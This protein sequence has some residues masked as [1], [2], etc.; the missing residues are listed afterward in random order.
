M[1]LL[2]SKTKSFIIHSMN[3][4]YSSPELYYNRWLTP[5]LRD[6][7]NDTS[8]LVLTGARQV[9]KSTLLLHEAPFSDF[10]FLTLDDF[11]TLQQAKGDPRSLFSGADRIVID[12]VQRE[13]D[14]LLAVKQTVDENPSRYK[15]VLS[16]SANLLLMKQVSES[17]A[18]RAIYFE[19]NPMTLGE[20]H[21]VP[22]PSLIWDMLNGVWP[23]EGLSKAPLP[24]LPPLLLRGLMPSLLHLDH[25]HSWT[26]WWDGYV[27]TYLERDL[28]QLSQIDSLLDFRRL[29]MLLALR[30]GQILNQSELARD[31]ELSQP[32][33]HRYINLLETSYLFKRLPPF[34]SN[35]NLR[36]IKSPKA[37]WSDPGLVAY[38]SGYYQEDDLQEAREY[39]QIFETFIFHHLQVITQLLTP[40]AHLFYWRMRSGQEIDFVLQHGRKI[41]PIEVKLTRKPGYDDAKH[42]RLFLEN[43]NNADAGLLITCGQEIKRLGSNIMAVPWTMLSG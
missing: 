8:I 7:L 35:R 34:T 18:G 22:P 23:E 36:L 4:S 42:L 9:G 31:G 15:F 26:R 25:A 5:Y 17:L 33:A 32:T 30:S 11:N 6:A 14:L 2:T 12:E 28:R 19:L 41:L 16:G 24:K 21:Q 43:Y 27:T 1:Y 20:I 37:F 29:M 3:K 38:L 39:G 13:P 40:K 10:R